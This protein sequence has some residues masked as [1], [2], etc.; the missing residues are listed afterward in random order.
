[1]GISSRIEIC[2]KKNQ[3]DINQP[4]TSSRSV[5]VIH[6]TI[7]PIMNTESEGRSWNY[8]HLET[9][10]FLFFW[11]ANNY[12]IFLFLAIG[13]DKC[14]FITKSSSGWVKEL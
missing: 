8:H 5:H 10:L 2:E 6:K 13:S 1:M 14:T 12:K 7:K 4:T 3:L 11:R 9:I